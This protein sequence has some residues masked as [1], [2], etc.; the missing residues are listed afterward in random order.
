V[1]KHV[2]T[3]TKNVSLH[4][5]LVRILLTKVWPLI[6]RFA[7]FDD[8]HEQT[9]VFGA[10]K[11]FRLLVIHFLY[12]R[13]TFDRVLSKKTF[14]KKL[15]LVFNSELFSIYLFN[16]ELILIKFELKFDYIYW[17]YLICSSNFTNLHRSLCHVCDISRI[18]C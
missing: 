9:S 12:D 7:I 17:T 2:T 15:N 18:K 16:F 11:S 5:I 1:S 13:D 4:P 14:R 6:F 8:C 10:Y 3:Y